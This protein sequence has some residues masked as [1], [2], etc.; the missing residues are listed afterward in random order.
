MEKPLLKLYISMMVLT[1][2]FAGC[3]TINQNQGDPN[4]GDKS[5]KSQ[6]SQTDSSTPILTAGTDTAPS[7]VKQPDAATEPAP[8]TTETIPAPISLWPR[9]QAGLQLDYTNQPRVQESIN[10][11]LKNRNILE[12]SQQR[13]RYFLFFIMDELQKQDVPFDVALIPVIESHYNPFAS[14]G[15]PAGL[16]QFMPATGRR[17][18]LH[19][20]AIYDGRKDPVAS[21]KAAASYFRYLMDMFDN[22]ILLS[23]AAYNSG[24]GT[25]KNAINKNLRLGKPVDYWHLD[26]P[27]VTR[28][29]IPKMLALAEI[30]KHPEKY[31][32]NLTTIEDQAYFTTVSLSNNMSLAQLA[33]ALKIHGD[34]LYTLNAGLDRHS[35]PYNTRYTVNIPIS[36]S[37]DINQLLAQKMQRA[38]PNTQQHLIQSGE[39]L[40]SIAQ[41]YQISVEQLKDWNHLTTDVIITGKTLLVINPDA[42]NAVKNSAESTSTQMSSTAGTLQHKVKAGESLWKIARIYKVKVSA[43]AGWNQKSMDSPLKTGETLLIYINH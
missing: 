13:A 5:H 22:D 42:R 39:T 10:W 27:P 32:L 17:F 38:K 25:V 2:F 29:Y 23:L 4:Q 43:L 8:I 30:F 1:L 9:F 24:E 18:H 33:T 31:Q 12:E 19:K 7:T 28:A 20:N 34:E 21:S 40:G 15:Q 37:A 41:Q 3:Q 36:K 6:D 26:L 11:Y 16:W 35:R 14:G